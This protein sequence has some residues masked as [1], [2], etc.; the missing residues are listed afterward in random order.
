MHTSV[1][2]T[3]FP[4]GS[5]YSSTYGPNTLRVGQTL[6]PDD[7]FTS[8]PGVGQIDLGLE[9]GSQSLQTTMRRNEGVGLLGRA[10]NTI[11]WKDPNENKVGPSLFQPTV[12]KRIAEEYGSHPP[13]SDKGRRYNRKYESAQEV[14]AKPLVGNVPI[15]LVGT[16]HAKYHAEHN[17]LDAKYSPASR[18]VRRGCIA[19]TLS[20]MDP[21]RPNGTA[22]VNVELAAPPQRGGL[23]ENEDETHWHYKKSY[24]ASHGPDS[25]VARRSVGGR[26]YLG[27]EVSGDTM[28]QS[29]KEGIAEREFFDLGLKPR[30]SGGQPYT[31]AT[32]AREDATLA[33]R[34][35]LTVQKDIPEDIMQATRDAYKQMQHNIFVDDKFNPSI[36][37]DNTAYVEDV[38]QWKSAQTIANMK[39][40][41]RLENF[42]QNV[43][44][45]QVR[46]AQLRANLFRR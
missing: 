43:N 22:F 26:Y 17:R 31:K 5:L 13:F 36:P 23:P 38:S 2:S 16:E 10:A 20:G 6:Q 7:V 33:K 30:M 4:Q 11:I 40:Q 19:A 3:S 45:Q 39:A 21:R 14:I 27:S 37:S 34:G 12:T 18:T 44:Q 15:P 46:E 1:R 41:D 35:R 8:K 32:K 25:N 24:N 28:I 9:N 29:K 42:Q